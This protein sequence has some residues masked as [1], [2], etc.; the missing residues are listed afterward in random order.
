MTID[1]NPSYT[2]LVTNPY[3]ATTQTSK[4]NIIQTTSSK[5]PRG[6]KKK[7]GTSKK[8]YFK[9]GGKQTQQPIVEGNKNKCK[10]K[11]PC[12]VCK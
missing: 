11:Y 6:K 1:N 2:T 10:F 4:V 3:P 7:N 8:N 9:L 5:K 12:M